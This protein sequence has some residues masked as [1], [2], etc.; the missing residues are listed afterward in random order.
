MSAD[1]DSNGG[2][3][4]EARRS[5]SDLRSDVGAAISIAHVTGKPIL[6]L[7]VGQGYD[8]LERFDPDEMLDRLLEDEA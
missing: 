7:G 8:D 4:S 1:A 6:F 3:P 5:S 2:E